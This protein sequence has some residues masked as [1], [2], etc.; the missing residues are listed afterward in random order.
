ML[1][2]QDRDRAHAYAKVDAGCVDRLR[3]TSFSR[4][5]VIAQHAHGEGDVRA[6]KTG[7]AHAAEQD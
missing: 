1:V 5:G 3:D 2:E 6:H 7:K 4:E